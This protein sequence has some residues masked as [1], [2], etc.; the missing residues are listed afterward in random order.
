MPKC[1]R[2]AALFDL[3]M[4]M[5][6]IARLVFAMKPAVD[7]AFTLLFLGE[8]R[9]YTVNFCKFLREKLTGNRSG[10]STT[11]VTEFRRR[12]APTNTALPSTVSGHINNI[13]DGLRSPA[14]A[15]SSS[16]PITINTIS[17]D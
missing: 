2:S 14:L 17:T 5:D 6:Y 3:S 15:R 13:K 7:A 12:P 1:F 8:Y 11:R 4:K 16:L 10:A 9:Q